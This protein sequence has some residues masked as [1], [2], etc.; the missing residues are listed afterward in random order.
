MTY[1]N[2][3]ND[4]LNGFE[5]MRVPHFSNPDISYNS[6]ATGDIDFANAAQVIRNGRFEFAGF[7]GSKPAFTGLVDTFSYQLDFETYTDCWYQPDDDTG[8]WDTI[9]GP[10]PDRDLNEVTGPLSASSGDYYMY[11]ESSENYSVETEHVLQA[12]INFT[13]FV[14][15]TISFDY[16]MYLASG[17]NLYLEAS[18]DNGSNWST[19]WSKLGDQGDGWKS[20]L[21]DLS[22]YDGM[23][24]LLRFRG[25]TGIFFLSDIALDNFKV[26]SNSVGAPYTVFMDANYP[27]LLDKCPTSDPDMDGMI[28]FLE[29]AFGM[30]LDTP[31][32]DAGPSTSYD[33]V[34]DELSISFKRAQAGVRYLVEST[35]DLDFA[36]SA[37]VEWDSDLSP[38]D[39][40]PVGNLQTVDVA[41]PVGGELFLQVEAT[42]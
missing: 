30:L 20:A 21:V 36:G 23:E 2:F 6:I 27:G 26:S 19:V 34:A 35:D 16:H 15:A 4:G 1:E 40:V 29:Y 22:A 10:T 14:H 28:N 41:M 38:P 7:R 11:I 3:D 33:D 8:E 12:K 31:D 39:L 18:T 17:G 5:Y 13:G 24:I 25:V 42:E 32:A 9:S 37:V